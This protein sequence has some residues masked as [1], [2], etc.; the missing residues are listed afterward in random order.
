MILGGGS[1]LTS[2][3]LLQEGRGG[4]VPRIQQWYLLL[5]AGR[6]VCVNVGVHEAMF[7]GFLTLCKMQEDWGTEKRVCADH[8]GVCGPKNRCVRT[9]KT[10]GVR[11]LKFRSTENRSVCGP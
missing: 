6:S 9:R 10:G 5:E 8:T 7:A 11:T 2:E 1:F 4:T 3:V